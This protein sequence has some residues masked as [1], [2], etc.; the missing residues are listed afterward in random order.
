MSNFK[1]L[2]LK[3]EQEDKL[4][5]ITHVTCIEDLDEYMKQFGGVIVG[6][7]TQVP[8]GNPNK[9]WI[10]TTGEFEGVPHYWNGTAWKPTH[11]VWAT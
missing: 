5:P 7:H 8:E 1:P 11:A 2:E 3:S 9:L 4:Y 10:H 6:I